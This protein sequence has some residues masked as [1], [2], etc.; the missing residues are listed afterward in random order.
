M[1]ARPTTSCVDTDK[2]HRSL[3]RAVALWVSVRGDRGKNPLRRAS[4]SPRGTDFPRHILCGEV[5]LAQDGSGDL[6]LHERVQKQ[7]TNDVGHVLW[8]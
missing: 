7:T 2:W 6:V 3:R 8:D 1:G 4:G 5:D